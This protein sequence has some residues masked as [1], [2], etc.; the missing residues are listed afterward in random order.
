MASLQGGS[1][2][3][4]Q[5]PYWWNS[6]ILGWIFWMVVVMVMCDPVI[7]KRCLG[8]GFKHFRSHDAVRQMVLNIF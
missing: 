6:L 8:G 4:W 7:P 1:L 2:E 3:R 5:G